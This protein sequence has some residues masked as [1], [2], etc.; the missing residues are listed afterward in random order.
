MK[1]KLIRKDTKK[2]VGKVFKE[3]NSYY[4]NGSWGNHFADPNKDDKIAK[5]HAERVAGMYGCKV[6]WIN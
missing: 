4:L 6:E 2:E 3:K 5:E 1:G